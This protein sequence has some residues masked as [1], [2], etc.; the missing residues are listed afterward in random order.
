LQEICLSKNFRKLLSYF[1]FTNASDKLN[2]W[3]FC[4]DFSLRCEVFSSIGSEIATSKN[5]D[6]NDAENEPVIMHETDCFERQNG[7]IEAESSACFH[8]C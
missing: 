3:F 1:L 2:G 4:A 5:V 6:R 8:L 7:Y